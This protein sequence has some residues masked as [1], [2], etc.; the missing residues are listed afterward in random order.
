[1]ALNRYTPPSVYGESGG[2]KYPA[3]S[4]LSHVIA[5]VVQTGAVVGV[6][7]APVLGLARGGSGS[8][9]LY[10]K[11]LVTTTSAAAVLSA[12]FAAKLTFDGEMDEESV[13]DMAFRLT[14]H[15]TQPAVDYHGMVGGCVG[16]TT[17]AIFGKAALRSVFTHSM[18]GIAIG[19]LSHTAY[20]HGPDF[21]AS[22]TKYVQEKLA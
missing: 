9:N 13:N 3:W 22:S 6:V 19:V 1:M 15:A 11:V 20:V 17:G 16:A 8:G 4:L 21:L 7:A 2:P 12:L 18:T 5:K 14:R 10:L